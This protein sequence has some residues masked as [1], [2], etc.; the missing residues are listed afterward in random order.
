V[1]FFL[2]RVATW[3]VLVCVCALPIATLTWGRF[4]PAERLGE[5]VGVFVWVVV[6]VIFAERLR[7]PARGDTPSLR[8]ALLSVMWS[9]W[10]S[11]EADRRSQMLRTGA[12]ATAI[13]HTGIA[14][15]G[16]PLGLFLWF[17]PAVLVVSYLPLIS[18]IESGFLAGL[19]W[20]LVCGSQT[21]IVAW[22][23]GRA[24]DRARRARANR[25]A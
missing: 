18:E 20:T 12:L 11:R 9:R 2:G 14:I 19:T 3:V 4:T 21:A 8:A 10:T 15:I 22:L 17:A 7:W 24:I 1:P 23:C 25:L 6:M 16:G 5:I 13:V